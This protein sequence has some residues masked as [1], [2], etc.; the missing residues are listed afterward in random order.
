[1]KKY[2]FP[3]IAV[4][5]AMTSCSDSQLLGDNAGNLSAS[6]SANDVNALIEKA[7]WGD[8]QAFLKLADCYRDGKGV[9]RDFIGMLAMAAQ[10]EEYGGISNTDDYLRALPEGSDF[11][12]IYNAIDVQARKDAATADS[13]ADQLIAKGSPDGY[14]VQGFMA[15]ERSDTLGGLR[16]IEQAASEGSTLA[17]LILCI[18]DMHGGKE[19]YVE[20]LAALSEDIPFANNILGRIYAGIEDGKVKDEA[21]AAHYF[22]KADKNASLSKRGAR[23]L[24]NYHRSGAKLPLS[25]QDIQRLQILAGEPSAD[26]EQQT[27][28]NLEPTSCRN[29][30]LEAYISNILEA[31]LSEMNCTK[32]T[33]YVVK[34]ET[35]AVEAQVSLS[36]KGTE[37][38]PSEDTYNNEQSA[39]I[40]GPTYLALLSTKEISPHSFIDTEH[41]IYKDVRDHNWRRGGYGI[42]TL[43]QALGRRSLV[44]FA[45]AKE[46]VFGNNT[47][48]L[49]SKVAEYLAGMPDSPMGILTFYNAVA[50]GGRMVKLHTEGDE[51]TVLNEQIAEPAHIS[52]LQRGLKQAVRQGIFG[53]AERTYTSVAA[54]GR[55]LTTEGNNRRME[56]CGYF[57]ANKPLYTIMVILE[58]D[59]LPAGAAGMCAPLMGRTIDLLLEYYDLREIYEYNKP[60][61]TVEAVDT[62]AVGDL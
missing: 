9:K 40:A 37:Y 41:G 39:L 11:S 8:G 60:Q 47:D 7:R 14:A 55:T 58:K 23:W 6:S 28:D 45:K 33:I 48:L 56:L 57:P 13:L 10:A 25:E 24:L 20:K 5:L 36:R 32:G 18:P 43:E 1:M 16:L 49:D 21:L 53:K 22:L 46:G 35:G 15:M 34:T 59:G 50:N 3:I 4:L 52:A 30:S 2:L 27:A 61:E 31:H 42:L 19:T 51:V 12:L 44:A 38:V 17:S 62:I 26:E 54:C 29:E